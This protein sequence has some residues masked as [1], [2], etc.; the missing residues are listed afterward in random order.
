MVD[1]ALVDYQTYGGIASQGLGI[2]TRLVGRGHD[3]LR[4]RRVHAGHFCMKFDAQVVATLFVLQETDQGADSRIM[5]MAGEFFCYVQ[6]RTVIARGIGGRKKQFGIGAT[7][8]RSPLQ[9]RTGPTSRF[10]SARVPCE[11]RA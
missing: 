11:S 7:L 8:F 6:Q 1:I 2:G 5:H 10:C 4:R 9:P 3:A